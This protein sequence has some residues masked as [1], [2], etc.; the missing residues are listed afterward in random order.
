MRTSYRLDEALLPQGWAR[1]VGL[2]VEDGTIIAVT[3]DAPPGFGERVVG[4]SIPGLPN[5]H[6]HLF[7][8]AMAGLAERRGLGADSFWSWREVMYGFLARLTP[9]DVEAIAAMAMV[10]MLEGGFTA[11]AE[12]HY[13]HHAPDGTPYDDPAEMAVRIAAAAAHTGIGLTLLPVLYCHGGFGAQPAGE[14]QRRFVST[15]DA[16]ARLRDASAR[17]IA[18]LEDARLGAAPHSLR[19][20]TT[21]QIAALL[22]LAPDR[23]VH[24]H[25]AEQVA[26]VQGCLAWCG[27]RPVA[28]LLA[29]QPVGPRWCLIHATHM[30]EAETVTLAASGAVAGL[31]PITEANL[32]DGF[33]PALDY[34]GAWGV[35][36]DSNVEITAPGELR[37]L[38]Y[39]QRLLHRGRNLM[40]RA[41]GR[42]TGEAMVRAALAGGSQAC[43]RDIGRLAPGARADIVVLP[44]ETSLDAWV[45]TRPVPLDVMVGGRWQVRQGRHRARD[46]VESAFARAMARLRA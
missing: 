28:H 35:G 37:L 13:L 27:Q 22:E 33:F 4:C 12:F 24:I 8:R 25:V 3:P 44:A 31:C 14:G 36:S 26:E 2:T 29:T 16:Y 45:F 11:L 6:S 41:A 39:G 46:T 18:P 1:H 5:L 7:Q 32:G 10:E 15:L 43:G 21:E 38:E 42:S 19:A 34:Q 20:A 17:A 9:D 30:S 40:A 23:P